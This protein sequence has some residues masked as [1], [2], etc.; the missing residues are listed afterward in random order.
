MLL[1]GEWCVCTYIHYGAVE[2]LNL[3]GWRVF[4]GVQLS[5]ANVVPGRSLD[6]IASPY[7]FAKLISVLSKVLHQQKNQNPQRH[8]PNKYSKVYIDKINRSCPCFSH[9]ITFFYVRIAHSL[10]SPALGLTLTETHIVCIHLII[11]AC[12]LSNH[13]FVINC[14]SLLSMAQASVTV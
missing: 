13:N 12:S 9:K 4:W 2:C 7:Q 1:Q 5:T 3:I 11:S 6:R 10:L 14:I 8:W